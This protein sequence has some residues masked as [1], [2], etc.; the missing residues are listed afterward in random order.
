MEKSLLHRWFEGVTLSRRVIAGVLVCAL[1]VAA[2][3]VAH[4][5]GAGPER[6]PPYNE[7]SEHW[8]CNATERAVCHASADADPATGRIVESV[9]IRTPALADGHGLAQGSGEMAMRHKMPSN[10]KTITGIVTLAVASA[11]A[12]A[13]AGDEL[14]RVTT[15]VRLAVACSTCPDGALVADTT[16]VLVDSDGTTDAPSSLS[17]TIIQIPVTIQ[18]QPGQKLGEA[19]VRAS[20]T[21][22]AI[23][24][25]SVSPVEQYA[26]ATTDLTVTKIELTST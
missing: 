1:P 12:G 25:R 3:A 16:K 15:F 13:S 14:G 24:N 5:R 19:V 11:S 17:E 22:Q 8:Y 4:A 10:S 21:A 23:L 9:D 7:S 18:V 20:V 26:T 2:P 6:T